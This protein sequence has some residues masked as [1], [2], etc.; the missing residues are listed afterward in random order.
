[1]VSLVIFKCYSHNDV[2]NSEI[3]MITLE[4]FYYVYIK[5]KNVKKRIF[6]SNDYVEYAGKYCKI[7]VI[8]LSS[9]LHCTSDN[10]EHKW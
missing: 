6:K 8:I 10:I 4:M 9:F 7:F 5:V 2:V 1:M 3:H